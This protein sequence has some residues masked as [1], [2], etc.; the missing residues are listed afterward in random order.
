MTDYQGHG[1]KPTKSVYRVGGRHPSGTMATLT[2]MAESLESAIDIYR[3]ALAE[4]GAYVI[5]SAKEV[6]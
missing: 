1:T 4:G 2:L 6:D 5:H 3:A